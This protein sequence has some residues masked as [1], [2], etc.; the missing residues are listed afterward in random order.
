MLLEPALASNDRRLEDLAFAE[1][2]C[3]WAVRAWVHNAER[4]SSDAVPIETGFRLA[5]IEPALSSLTFFLRVIQT[6]AVR[7]LE[8]RCL[9]CPHVSPDEELL[10]HAIG[11]LQAGQYIGAQIVLHRYL[12]CSAVRATM[13]SLE[14]FAERLQRGNLKLP[15]NDTGREH[16]EALAA[17]AVLPSVALH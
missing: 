16:I 17:E 1:Q 8:I 3:V 12:P 5:K 6:A 4:S 9:H 10:L 11:A 15:L 7:P 13:W 14:A 2:F